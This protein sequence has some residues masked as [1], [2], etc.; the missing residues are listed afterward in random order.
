MNLFYKPIYW[1]YR[2]T[3]GLWYWARRR[4]TLAG[5]AV[6]A[7]L[8]FTG[9]VG[10]DIENTVAYQ[11]FALLFAVAL[12][13]FGCSCF[14]RAKFSATRQLPRVGTAGQPMPYKIV[15]KNLTRKKQFGLTLLEDLADPRPSFADWLAFQNA[16]ERRARP[17]RVSRRKR[18][19]PFHL[20]DAKAAEIEPLP[21][22]GECEVRMELFP[23]RRGILHFRGVTV[24]RPDPFGLYRAFRRVLA[25][26]TVLILPRRYPLPPIA[27]PGA[28]RYQQGGVALAA[29]VG[30]SEEFVALREYRRGD[31]LR[32]IHWRSWAKAG[33]PIVKEY[34][35]EFFVRHAL[36]LD[37]FDEE[38][39]S[40][41]LEEAVS[42]TSSFACTV[43]TQESL[44]D[45]LFVGNESYC[46][47]AGRGLA[48][49]NQMLEILASVKNCADKPFVTL[50]HLVL[51][52]VS[53]VSGCICVLQRWDDARRRFIEK[54]K[55]LGVPLLVL[56]VV[57]PGEGIPG[58]GGELVDAE[59]SVHVLEVGKMEQSLAKLK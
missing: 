12:F 38:P 9:A 11:A 37:T 17:F 22:Q 29:N 41:I 45:L 43:L 28:M 35:D 20:A 32:H 57:P 30:S 15:V 46:F 4:F 44:L 36:V 1:S 19:N 18:R 27:L 42:V 52:H 49:A 53:L 16:E 7:A 54:L 56:I 58:A 47:T 24:A 59:G 8:F 21:P 25:A 55:A 5:W 48:H 34:E 39:N 23:R 33:K 6:A 31:P 10:V 50:E 40:E 3:G 2:A 51:N 14:F 13:S 26:Q